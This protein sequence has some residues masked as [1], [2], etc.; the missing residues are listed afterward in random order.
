MVSQ[1]GLYSCW[2][3]HNPSNYTQ[4]PTHST[5]TR[6]KADTTVCP[7]LANNFV[8]KVCRN[9]ATTLSDHNYMV[10]CNCW[11]ADSPGVSPLLLQDTLPVPAEQH[12]YQITVLPASQ[13]TAAA[14]CTTAWGLQTLTHPP[15]HVKVLVRLHR[16]GF[17]NKVPNMPITGQHLMPAP[18][19][20]SRKTRGA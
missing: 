18:C 19:T 3:L 1:S 20:N 6:A 14:Q 2:L 7:H 4:T 17:V 16:S 9:L 12:P 15:H 11:R 5:A 10:I 13:T 8:R